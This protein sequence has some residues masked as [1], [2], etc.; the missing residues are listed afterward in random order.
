MPSRIKSLLVPRRRSLSPGWS[1]CALGQPHINNIGDDVEQSEW[2]A[3][4]AA[5]V[6]LRYR[7]DTRPFLS[8][9]G[10]GLPD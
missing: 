2:A 7:H 8:C 3:L 10:A 9:E 6:Q 4:L 1:A 5:A